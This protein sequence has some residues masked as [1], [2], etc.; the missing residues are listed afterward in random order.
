MPVGVQ[1]EIVEPV[2]RHRIYAITMAAP[3][4]DRIHGSQTQHRTALL[5]VDIRHT[6]EGGQLLRQDTSSGKH[7]NSFNSQ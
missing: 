4:R 1:P 6:A 7:L 2:K 5:A 3:G